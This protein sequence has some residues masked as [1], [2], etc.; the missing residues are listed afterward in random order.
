METR[1]VTRGHERPLRVLLTKIG[2]DGHDR[3]L[4]VVAA[5][6]RDAGMEVIYLG[7]HRTCEAI[8]SA[9]VQ[10]DV[11]V[12]GLSSLGG[13]H[14]AHARAV[15]E[16]LRAHGAGHLP[17]VLGGTL[18]VE[19]IPKLEEAGVRAVFLPGS[20]REEIVATVTRLGRA[21]RAAAVRPDAEGV[22]S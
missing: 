6:L 5:L 7:I 11:D 8:V 15:I 19:D 17:V 9:A 21:T 4:K 10:E 22:Q 14:L 18:P 2:L 16:Q 1:L 20:S 13:T 12:I 3:G